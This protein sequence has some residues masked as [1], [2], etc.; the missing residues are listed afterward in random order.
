MKIK[1]LKLKNFGKFTD[2]EIEF[3][4]GVTN[5]VGVNGSGKSSMLTAIW[6]TL[7]GIAEKNSNGQLIG[8]RFRFI[9]G[10]AATAEATVLLIDEAKGNSQIVVKNKISKTGNNITFEAPEGYPISPE[11]LNSLLSVAFL[12]A[13][14]FCQLSGREQ[15]VLLGID[16]AKFDEESKRLKTE[17]TRI[18]AELKQYSNLEPVAEVQAVDV[19][20]LQSKKDAI[21]ERLNAKYLENKAANEKLRKA[22]ED[23]KM[24][25][26]D[27]VNEF[28]KSNKYAI[29][30]YN[31]CLD[32]AIVLKEHGYDTD[33]I[34]N[35]LDEKAESIKKDKLASELYPVEPTYIEERPE[36][37]DLQ[38]IDSEVMNAVQTNVKA[39]AFAEYK[40]KLSEADRLETER[41]NNKKDQDNNEAA[42]IEYI[43]TFDFG[44]RGLGVDDEGSLLL[45]G[46]P[47][48]D[49][50]FSKG[51]LE[52]IVA[53]LYAS[54]NP[55]LKIRFI[56]EF[57]NLDED[58]QAKIVNDLIEAGFQIITTEPGKVAKS[59][60]TILLR[61]CKVVDTYE[62]PS[63]GE[64]L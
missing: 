25:I 63:Q 48:K 53:K 49:P 36:D 45:N 51:E 39:A 59:D 54:L 32:A 60:N 19:T 37:T 14:N 50:Y 11:W 12:S 38:A 34:K 2:F 22:W 41:A 7:K 46:R 28:N 6:A 30:S 10:Q 61:E 40:K 43:K 20:E 52:I 26:F 24:K 5:L 15:A 33:S 21:R 1:G 29:A 64:L 62:Q 9:G 13:K 47:I 4:G 3:N 23:E 16:T 42:K 31:K 58:N 57:G 27:E 55:D 18:N 17:F 56:D 44:F 8:E 35:F